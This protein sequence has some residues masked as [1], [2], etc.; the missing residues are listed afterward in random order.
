[1]EAILSLK[2]MHLASNGQSA[3][4]MIL[5]SMKSYHLIVILAY[6]RV[7]KY[8]VKMQINHVLFSLNSAEVIP[9]DDKVTEA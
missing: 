5:F 1:M 6:P 4:R 7:S 3:I 8:A 9:W 2:N